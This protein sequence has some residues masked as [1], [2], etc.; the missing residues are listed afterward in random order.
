ME[1]ESDSRFSVEGVSTFLRGPNT[2]TQLQNDNHSRESNSAAPFKV[3][4]A[5]G[6]NKSIIKNK[7]IDLL[8]PIIVQN[9]EYVRY[10]N[11]PIE[12]IIMICEISRRTD[13]ILTNK[14]KFSGDI[15]E[16][17]TGIIF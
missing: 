11:I 16:N 14:I 5:G 4:D 7:N 1:F 12:L 6:E 8:P 15:P 13:T 3:Q 10:D 9:L 17:K 2:R